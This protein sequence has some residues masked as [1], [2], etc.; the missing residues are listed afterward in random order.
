MVLAEAKIVL[1]KDKINNKMESK[2][3][4]LSERFQNSIKKNHRNKGKI[5]SPNM[6]APWLVT[7]TSIKNGGVKLRRNTK[8]DCQ[9]TS[10]IAFIRKSKQGYDRF[11]SSRG[12]SQLIY[13]K[14][15]S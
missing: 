6:T 15:N 14:A 11:V 9:K 4:F 2:N 5:D 12:R 3:T 10:S 1:L 7:G 13:N 8:K